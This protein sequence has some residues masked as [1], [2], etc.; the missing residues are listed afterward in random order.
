MCYKHPFLVAF[1]DETSLSPKD[2][3]KEDFDRLKSY[4]AQRD[5]SPKPLAVSQDHGV[6]SGTTNSLAVH[7]GIVALQQGGNAM[8]ACAATA[9]TGE[10]ICPLS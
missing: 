3:P 10:Q 6:V 7:A 5:H 9:L 2:W 8:D 4:A 1:E